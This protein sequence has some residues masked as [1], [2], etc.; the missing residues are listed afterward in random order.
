MCVCER[1]RD[2]GDADEGLFK[3]IITAGSKFEKHKFY[4]NI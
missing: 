2:S 1:E 3:I 4:F